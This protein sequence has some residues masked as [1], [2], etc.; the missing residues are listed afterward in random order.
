MPEDRTSLPVIALS[1]KEARFVT[2]PPLP[3]KTLKTA[4]ASGELVAHRVG[5]NSYITTADLRE[6]IANQEEYSNGRRNPR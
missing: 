1:P 6:W 5:V 3:A 2:R 4:L